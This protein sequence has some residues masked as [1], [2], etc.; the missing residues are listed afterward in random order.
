MNPGRGNSIN[1]DLSMNAAV[2]GASGVQAGAGLSPQETRLVLRDEGD[3]EGWSRYSEVCGL[4]CPRTLT[5]SISSIKQ[6]ASSAARPRRGVD[7]AGGR[8]EKI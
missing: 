8:L 1:V 6:K 7:S 4:V 3:R 2:K 5:P